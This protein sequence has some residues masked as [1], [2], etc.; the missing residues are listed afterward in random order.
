VVEEGDKVLVFPDP[1]GNHVYVVAPVTLVICGV[2]LQIVVL[3][4][5]AITV[6]V[7]VTLMVIV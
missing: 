5:D 2:P 6:G 7:A 3:V 1:E 4:I